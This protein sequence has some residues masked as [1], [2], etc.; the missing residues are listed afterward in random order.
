[1]HIRDISFQN[2]CWLLLLV[3]FEIRKYHLLLGGATPFLGDG[4]TFLDEWYIHM[5]QKV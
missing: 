3:P 2:V 5:K 1:M 4:I